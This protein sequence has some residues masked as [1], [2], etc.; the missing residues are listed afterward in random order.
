[1]LRRVVLYALVSYVLSDLEG[2]VKALRGEQ[3]PNEDASFQNA[4]LYPTE[5]S[6]RCHPVTFHRG[7][8][9]GPID[10][11]SFKKS[12]TSLLNLLFISTK[13]L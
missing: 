8:E 3:V 9:A 1:M 10:Q 12:R 2:L 13:M 11:L 6:P 5:M 7:Q 4:S